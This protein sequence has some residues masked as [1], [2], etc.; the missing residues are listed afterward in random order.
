ME[1]VAQH[2][3]PIIGRFSKELI[4]ISEYASDPETYSTAIEEF[5][6]YIKQGFEHRELRSCPVHFKFFDN[7]EETIKTLEL[8]HLLTNM[9][10]WQPLVL[11]DKYEEINDSYV[12]DC[13]HMTSG[14]LKDYY[15]N[16]IIIPFRRVVKQKKLNMALDEMIYNLSRI[17]TDFNII[18]GLSINTET[19]I[20]LAKR[21]P[22]FNE[23]I[24]TMID[25]GMQPNEIEAILNQLML[26][27][28]EIIKNDPVGNFLQPI[29]LTETGIRTKQLAEFSINGGLKPDLDGKTIP[30]PINANFIVRGLSNIPNYYIDSLGGRKSVIMNK[31][32]M[33]RSGH[34]SR[35]IMLATSDIEMHKHICDCNT[36]NPVQMFVKTEKHLKRLIGRYYREPHNRTYKMLTGL[37]KHLIGKSILVRSPITCASDKV[38]SMCYGDLYYTNR[39]LRSIGG[40]AGA[41][42]TEPL[43]QMILSS[44]HLLTTQSELIEFNP[45]FYSMFS[46]S[47]N[48]IIL[49]TENEDFEINDYTMVVLRDNLQMLD[50]FDDSEFNSFLP[51]FH[52]RNKRTGELI[53]MK[54]LNDKELY[55]SSDIRAL[56]D[57]DKS[58]RDIVEIDLA[59]IS[60]EESIFAVEISNN[61]LTRPLYRIMHL[62]NRSDHEGQT[63]IDGMA[64]MLLD[65]LIE[66]SIGADSVHGELLI[67]PLIRKNGKKMKDI[68]ERPDFSKYMTNSDYT[69]LTVQGAL[70]RH[71]SVLVSMSFQGLGRQLQNPL[72]FKKSAT[73][74]V[75]PFFKERP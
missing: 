65:L 70:E 48:M 3:L 29:L 66:S 23:I 31:T 7:T 13:K 2:L 58:G 33:G 54:E 62:L 53:E 25:E 34:F 46:I 1:D 18:L 50:E 4:V 57:R 19:F 27:E 6:D 52:V 69:I 12:F 71:P 43:S 20:E 10:L 60:D 35:M 37:D 61:E 14:T 44:K 39:D 64:Q 47:A 75:D 30:K 16:K 28:V 26:E 51:L 63:D 55:L 41:R 17:S 24:R 22:R 15:D 56:I 21:N 9:M 5:Y 72:T 73:S 8:R 68:L 74:F 32:T 49:N 40:F 42:I 67:R 59:R 11:L 45:E 38:C 36:V